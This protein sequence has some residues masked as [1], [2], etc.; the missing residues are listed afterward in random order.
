MVEQLG[1]DQPTA[2]R[3]LGG[4]L[5]L[6]LLVTAWRGDDFVAQP[7]EAAL[8][9]LADTGDDETL[10][11]LRRFQVDLGRFRDVPLGDTSGTA[12]PAEDRAAVQVRLETGGDQL[13]R[14]AGRP[15]KLMVNEDFVLDPLAVDPG[16]YQ[17]ALDDLA[18]V[19]ELFWAFDRMHVV[20]ALVAAALAERFG[21]G[22]QVPLVEHAEALVRAT[23][24]AEAILAEHP[25]AAIGPGD[26]SLAMLAKV[27]REA[28]TALH[29]GADGTAD[30]QWAPGDVTA[31]VADAPDR[32]RLD[33]ASYGMVVQPDGADLVLNDTYAGHGPMV[34]RFLHADGLRGGTSVARLRARIDA[35][36]RPGAR[37]VE[38]RGAHGLSINAHPPILEESLDPGGWRGLQLA[39]D[40][41]TDVVSIVDA[42]G[43]PVTVLAL[44]AQLPELFPYPV[45]LATWLCSSGR[46]VLDVMAARHRQRSNGHGATVGYPRLRVGGVVV[47]RRRWYPGADFP[48]REDAADD[49]DHLVALTRWRARH[50]VPAE[51][52]LKSLFDGPTRW[53]SLSGVESRDRFFELRRHSKPQYVDLGSALMTRVLPRLMDRRPEGCIEE[54]RPALAGGGHAVEWMVEMARPAGDARFTWRAP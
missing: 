30:V 36:Y 17:G 1:V 31:L 45:R 22:C 44:G 49:I 37:L 27:R 51:V 25:E 33:P 50:D 4:A 53:E 12:E 47:S 29:H 41:E 46:V 15:A 54:A 34:S 16:T 32:F 11:G 6:G 28:M 23:Y 48:S 40:A 19:A 39:H 10:E 38:D 42:G 9:D 14:R 3:L 26:G 18:A 20:R 7:V 43:A 8:D 13:S 52:M 35:L 5:G 24:R 21:A 2:E